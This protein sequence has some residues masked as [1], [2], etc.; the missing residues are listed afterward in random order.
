MNE[1]CYARLN[2]LVTSATPPFVG[3][4]DLDRTLGIDDFRLSLFAY[5]RR[6]TD[7]RSCSASSLDYARLLH[8]DE[9]FLIASQVQDVKGE[10]N[11]ELDRDDQVPIRLG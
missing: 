8:R 1:E 5:S 7:D 6:R 3:E 10:R 2:E 11:D 9:R 4:S